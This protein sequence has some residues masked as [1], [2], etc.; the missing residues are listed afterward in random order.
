[1]L[2]KDIA[3]YIADQTG[4]SLKQANAVVDAFL[5][6]IRM[7]L[8]KGESVLLTG[9]GKFEVRRRAARV[10]INPQTKAKINLPAS[11]VPAFKAGKGLKDAVK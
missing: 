10:G 8:G 6:A 4:I 3:K 7:A 9:F 1:M 2:K 5:D 11:N